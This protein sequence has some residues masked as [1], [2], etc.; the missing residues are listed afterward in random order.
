MSDYE[1]HDRII[2]ALETRA[3]KVMECAEKAQKKFEFL[4]KVLVGSVFVAVVSVT[5][6]SILVNNNKRVINDIRKEYT[7]LWFVNDLNENTVFAIKEIALVFA[8]SV[9]KRK[10]DDL[11]NK[12]QTFTKNSLIRLAQL[13][14]ATSGQTRNYEPSAK[15]DSLRKELKKLEKLMEEIRQ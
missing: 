14:G 5:T 2:T 12:Y 3:N 11:M 10:L 8:D 13:K 7:P 6:L 4:F 1:K 9:D 15:D